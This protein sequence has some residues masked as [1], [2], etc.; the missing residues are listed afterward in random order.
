MATLT[1]SEFGALGDSAP[2]HLPMPGLFADV[3][4][5]SG[6]VALTDEFLEAAPR[7]RLEVLQQPH[8][9]FQRFL[10]RR[11][12][13]GALRKFVGTLAAAAR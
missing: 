10:P 12:A 1:A 3:E 9:V 11:R 8:K 4:A 5:G 7:L 6:A 13:G 2:L